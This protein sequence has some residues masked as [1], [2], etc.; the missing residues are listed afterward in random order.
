MNNEKLTILVDMD[1]IAADLQEKWYGAYNK[2]YNDTITVD[3]I[4]SWDTHKYVKPE[5]GKKIYKY[6]TPSIHW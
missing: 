2:R 3:D 5:C 6:F 4:L 1:S